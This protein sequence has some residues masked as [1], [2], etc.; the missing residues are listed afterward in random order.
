MFWLFCA[1]MTYVLSFYL[2]CTF[3]GLVTIPFFSFLVIHG[4]S[5]FLNMKWSY[6]SPTIKIVI[7]VQWVFPWAFVT[8]LFY[9]QCLNEDAKL[10]W[11]DSNFVTR[12][13][14]QI[15]SYIIN[16][17]TLMSMEPST[18]LGP[19]CLINWKSLWTWIKTFFE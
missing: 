2:P 18:T 17:N 15:L 10:I 12:D 6:L 16:I 14:S 4:F 13:I 7:L 5:F 3:C 8:N 19:I 11:Y 9:N 1:F